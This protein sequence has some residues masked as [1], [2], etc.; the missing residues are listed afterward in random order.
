MSQSSTTTRVFSVI[1]CSLGLTGAETLHVDST[2]GSDAGSG[3][4]GRPLRTL[5][6]A[7]MKVNEKGG[8]GSLAV[9][10]AGGIY[11]LP[12]AVV[13]ENARPFDS[14]D[15]LTIEASLLPDDPGWNPDLM[16]TILSIEDPRKPDQAGTRTSTYGLKIKMSHVTVRGL[17]FLGSPLP[18]NW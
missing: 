11:A 12:R 9:K 3:T 2:L 10:L 17:K 1:A 4:A 7:A 15:R 14:Q 16:P 13:F 8:H 18:N 6:M 5:A